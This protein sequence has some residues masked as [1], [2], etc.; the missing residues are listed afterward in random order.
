MYALTWAHI[1]NMVEK[2]EG[3]HREERNIRKT[4]K[5]LA[6]ES[7]PSPGLLDWDNRLLRSSPRLIRRG[8]GVALTGLEEEEIGTI[9]C[10]ERWCCLSSLLGTIHNPGRVSTPTQYT[11]MLALILPTSEG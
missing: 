7:R 4:R 10:A 8:A 6:G 2:T 1:H 11:S 5:S 3:I 9:L